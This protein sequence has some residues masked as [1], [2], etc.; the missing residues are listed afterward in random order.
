MDSQRNLVLGSFAFA[1]LWVAGMI[2]WSAPMS[3]A[4]AVAIT[5]VGVFAGLLWY[6]AMR[7]WMNWLVRPLW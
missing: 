5:I 6:L 4:R 2:W 1:L 3:I 7:L